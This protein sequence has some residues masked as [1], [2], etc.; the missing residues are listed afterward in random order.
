M[1]DYQ[2]W[3]K[4]ITDHFLQ[5]M[6]SG[7]TIYLSMDFSALYEISTRL[8]LDNNIDKLWKDDFFQSLRSHCLSNGAI[9]IRAI[10]G[11]YDDGIPRAVAFLGAMVLAAY[12]MIE[13]DTDEGIISETNYFKRLRMV[14]GL[15]IDG[16]GRPA[17][18]N[19]P[20]IEER[21][22]TNWNNYLL[23]KSYFPSAEPGQGIARRY[24]N[25]PLS[26]ALLR[27]ADKDRLE[28]IFRREEKAARLNSSMDMDHLNVWLKHNSHLINSSHLKGLLKHD[29]RKRYNT[30][31]EAIYDVYSQIEWDKELNNYGYN[32]ILD[33]QRRLIAGIYRVEDPFTGRIEYR[34]YPQEP[35]RCQVSGLKLINEDQ[36]YELEIE[37]S[38]WYYPL[39]PVNPAGGVTYPVIGDSRFKELVIPEKGFWILTRDPENVDSGIFASWGYP[40]LGDTFLLLCRQEYVDQLELLK[41]ENLLK[42]DHNLKLE[43]PLH[44]WIEYRECMVVSNRWE[45]II[46]VNQ[47]LYE[48]LMP[49]V[50]ISISLR[51]GLRLAPQLIWLEGYGPDLMVTGF[52]D[53]VRLQ[54]GTVGDEAYSITNEMIKTNQ[55]I[56]MKDLPPGSYVA[57]IFEGSRYLT[58]KSFRILSWDDLEPQLVKSGL[59]LNLGACNIEGAIVRPNL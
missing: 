8:K 23:K 3:N 55:P 43:G 54:L 39:M 1:P 12:L 15:D 4:A 28:R 44:G 48:A 11:F 6:P 51:N 35:K 25:F 49:S 26:Q 33:R 30:L 36:L 57:K 32:Y 7:A 5:G 50:T 13:E 58:M 46:P 21:L 41:Q 27:D 16:R 38:G 10:D 52:T 37:R 9:Q 29:D 19:P 40:E 24:I 56:S 42:W 17:G 2:Q 20:G 22:W 59:G 53:N 47:D 14:F 34:L 31:C 18:L 45:Y